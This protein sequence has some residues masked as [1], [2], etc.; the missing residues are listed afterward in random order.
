LVEPFI[1]GAKAAAARCRLTCREVFAGK[2]WREQLREW[3]ETYKPA[4]LAEHR[5]LQA[6]DADALSADELVAYLGRCRDHHA[7]MITQVAGEK[8]RSAELS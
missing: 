6:V 7:A 1:I 2:L 8:L 4:A 5:E 3:D